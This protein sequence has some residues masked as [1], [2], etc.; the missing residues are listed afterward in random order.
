M[1]KLIITNHKLCNIVSKVI[2]FK[3]LLILLSHIIY[4]WNHVIQFIVQYNWSYEAFRLERES[5]S[6]F[7]QIPPA[8]LAYFSSLKNSSI[9]LFLIFWLAR[10]SPAV[11]VRNWNI[12]RVSAKNSWALGSLAV[13]CLLCNIVSMPLSFVTLTLGVFHD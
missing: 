10:F 6:F 2:I 8:K 1:I 7:E 5:S 13:D 12:F 3:I 11:R 4:L 9:F